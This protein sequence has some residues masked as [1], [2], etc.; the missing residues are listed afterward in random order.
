[1]R[2]LLRE[3]GLTIVLVSA[4]LIFWG[5][6][7]V[8]GYRE[9][10]QEQKQH[11]QSG[12]NYW[13]YLGSSHFWEA[14]TENGESE[15]LQI[16]FYVF[17]TAFLYQKGSAESRKLD[18]ENPVDRDPRAHRLRRDAPWPVKR[19][20]LALNLYE[21]SLSIA[22]FLFLLGAI[23]LHAVSGARVYSQEQVDHGE[24]PMSVL[25]YVGTSRF[26]FE[27]FQNWQSE[28]LAIALVVVF[29][30]FLRQRGSP[31]SKPVDSPHSETGSG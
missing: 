20:G 5:G 24:A 11:E 28:F 10:Q 16:F 30:I 8:A 18:G 21:H 31:E 17:L 29:S 3:N 12:G 22:F 26:W 9:Y 2:R 1:M 7:S 23:T 6:Q 4:F 25:K 27:S 19:G 15:F 13:S 14:T